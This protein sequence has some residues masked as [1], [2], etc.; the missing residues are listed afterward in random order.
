MANYTPWDVNDYL[1]GQPLTSAKAI[2]YHENLDA[3]AA[4]ETG[5]PVLSTGWHPYN[6]ANVG[7]GNGAFYDFSVHGLQSSAESPNFED[8]YEYALVFSGLAHNNSPSAQF[9]IEIYKETDA[10]YATAAGVA[11]ANQN[12]PLF[13]VLRLPFC[14]LEN[15]AMTAVWET[16]AAAGS[17]G[18]TAT[19]VEVTDTTAQKIGKIRLAPVSGSF[20]AGRI[21]LARRRCFLSG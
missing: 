10:A 13:G 7:D 6:M 5:S 19:D 12:A 15:Y 20:S 21:I 2:S 14:R 4:G 16:A 3:T 8:G 11:S 17:G 9:N 18:S 1:P